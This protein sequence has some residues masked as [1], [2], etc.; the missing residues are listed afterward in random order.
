M[1]LDP[2]SKIR[3]CRESAGFRISTSLHDLSTT[4][5]F[6]SNEIPNIQHQI[7]VMIQQ[8]FRIKDR[9]ALVSKDPSGSN[10][11]RLTTPD[12]P[13]LVRENVNTM[14]TGIICAR[15]PWQ[16]ICSERRF[17]E[18]SAFGIKILQKI[19]IPFKNILYHGQ[20]IEPLYPSKIFS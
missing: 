20:D 8:L 11:L 6:S 15:S 4:H 9:C 10:V 13:L 16:D 12:C 2:R 3:Q 14:M 1:T 5:M 18:N 7:A 17:V 19:N